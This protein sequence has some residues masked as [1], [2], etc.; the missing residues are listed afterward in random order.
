MPVV[1]LNCKPNQGAALSIATS[2]S[3]KSS[4]TTTDRRFIVK[5][6]SGILLT[7]LSGFLPPWR[8][9]AAFSKHGRMTVLDRVQGFLAFIRLFPLMSIVGPSLPFLNGP[10]CCW[11]NFAA[12]WVQLELLQRTSLIYSYARRVAFLDKTVAWN[13][14]DFNFYTA[15]YRHRTLFGK[16]NQYLT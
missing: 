10:Q 7:L 14:Q 2:R 11:R 3:F 12:L 4:E 6:E 15:Q 13:V 8:C 5:S 1:L 9:W 16:E